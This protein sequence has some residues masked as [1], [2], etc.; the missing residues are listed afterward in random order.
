M[1]RWWYTSTYLLDRYLLEYFFFKGKVVEEMA[2]YAGHSP[3]FVHRGILSLPLFLCLYP[4]AREYYQQLHHIRE[5]RI[6]LIPSDLVS[7]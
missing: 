4:Q 6:S 1:L 5:A 7:R 3:F 2:S